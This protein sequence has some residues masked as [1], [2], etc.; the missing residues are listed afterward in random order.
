MG[1]PSGLHKL[2][3][4]ILVLWFR[5]DFADVNLAAAGILS[6]DSIILPF[7]YAMIGSLIMNDQFSTLN[8]DWTAAFYFSIATMSL[9]GRRLDPDT[10][11]R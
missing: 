6:I 3:S 2:V 1:L 4:L 8:K 9:T 10:M 11:V 5:R 7:D